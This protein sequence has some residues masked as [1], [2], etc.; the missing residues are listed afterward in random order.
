MIDFY[1]MCSDS[2]LSSD[3]L[4]DPAQTMLTSYQGSIYWQ[5]RQSCCHRCHFDL[6]E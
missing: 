2:V 3:I 4:T 5:R 1:K 6:R